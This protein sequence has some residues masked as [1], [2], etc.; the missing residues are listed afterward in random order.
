MREIKFRAW[1]TIKNKMVDHEVLSMS[2][3]KGEGFTFAFDGNTLDEDGNEEGSLNFELMQYTGLK[4][5]NGVE[6][7]EGDIIYIGHP[8]KGR[9]YTGPIIYE[10]YQFSAKDFY[11]THHD[12]PSDPFESIEYMEVIGNIHANPELLEVQNG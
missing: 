6:I 1:F 7:Y 9:T 12:N 4:D 3:D 2:Y 10:K 5:K 8:H 11:F